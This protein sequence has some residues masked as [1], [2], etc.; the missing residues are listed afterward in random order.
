MSKS[1]QKVEGDLKKME[2]RRS[3]SMVA[4]KIKEI[5]SANNCISD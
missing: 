3:E 1:K 2:I 5:K 4:T